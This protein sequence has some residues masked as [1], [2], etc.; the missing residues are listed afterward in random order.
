LCLDCLSCFLC[1][2]LCGLFLRLY[3]DIFQEA[4]S[5]SFQVRVMNSFNT[6]G[7]PLFQPFPCH[8]EI[9]PSLSPLLYV[10]VGHCLLNSAL[11]SHVTQCNVFRA[12]RG[13]C[14]PQLS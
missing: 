13:Y 8:V 10:V 4:F 7:L 14:A 3:R 5:W 9:T 1:Q 11:V 2:V 6:Y 12:C